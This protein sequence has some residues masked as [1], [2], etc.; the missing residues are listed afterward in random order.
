MDIFVYENGSSLDLTAYVVDEN[1]VETAL[2]RTSKGRDDLLNRI[3][4][5]NLSHL[6][7]EFKKEK[8]LLV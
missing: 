7:V 3:Q 2:A 4:A 8:R 1:G 6:T 5:L